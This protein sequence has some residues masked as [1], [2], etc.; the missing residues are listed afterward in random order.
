MK[1][2][3]L[4][5]IA[6]ALIIVYGLIFLIVITAMAWFSK[7]VT[8]D[9]DPTEVGAVE[10]SSLMASHA[11][12]SVS[13]YM[14]QTG[15]Y[16]DPNAQDYMF[17]SDFQ[18]ILTYSSTTEGYLT[19]LLDIIT[20]EKQIGDKWNITQLTDSQIYN[21]FTWRLYDDSY[22]DC[23]YKGTLNNTSFDCAGVGF[24]LCST[25]SPACPTCSG[26][27]KMTLS[28]GAKANCTDCEGFGSR[29]TP[30]PTCSGTG[31]VDEETCPSCAGR[32]YIRAVCRVCSGTGTVNDSPCPN[33][34]GEQYLRNLCQSCYGT[35]RNGQDD[36]SVCGGTGKCTVCSG[37][38]KY[39]CPY[40]NGTLRLRTT[41]EYANEN[42]FL[43]ETYKV[44]YKN[45]GTP[46]TRVSVDSLRK[47]SDTDVNSLP[48]RLKIFFIGEAAYS[49]IEALQ[50]LPY[51]SSDKIDSKY[52]FDFSDEDYMFSVFKITL[53]YNIGSLYSIN[54][55]MGSEG[56]RAR[57]YCASTGDNVTHY[58]T[59]GGEPVS[60]PVG[61]YMQAT[62]TRVN[63]TEFSDTEIYYTTSLSALPSNAQISDEPGLYY[64][65]DVNKN[66][67]V[68][69]EMK[70]GDFSTRP[71]HYGTFTRAYVYDSSKTYYVCDYD[72]R[73]SIE[74]GGEYMIDSYLYGWKLGGTSTIVNGTTD[75]Y[76]N[77]P[78][79]SNTMVSA[80]IR[81]KIKVDYYLNYEGASTTTPY[82]SIYVVPGKTINYAHYYER[83][84][85]ATD[86]VRA[87]YQFIG[88]SLTAEASKDLLTGN[89]SG[90]IEFNNNAVLNLTDAYNGVVTLY[91]IWAPVREYHL[92]LNDYW[93]GDSAATADYYI[94]SRYNGTYVDCSVDNE[95]D[96]TLFIPVGAQLVDYLSTRISASK[97]AMSGGVEGSVLDEIDIDSWLIKEND[98]YRFLTANT[99]V[100]FGLEPVTIYARWM[101]NFNTINVK[102][103]DMRVN[104][105]YKF[106]SSTDPETGDPVWTTRSS[107]NVKVRSSVT[108]SKVN[109]YDGYLDIPYA[110]AFLDSGY[111]YIGTC[112]SCNGSGSEE[113]TCST[114]S[115]VGT[116]KV[117]C[118]ICGGAG[119]VEVAC[120]VCQEGKVTCMDCGGSGIDDKCTKCNGT[121]KLKCETC[122]GLGV[123]GA[124][125]CPDCDGGYNTC[126]DCNGS[127]DDHYCTNCSGTGFLDCDVCGGDGLLNQLCS[128]CYQGKVTITC[129]TC[130]GA[131]KLIQVC[132]TCAGSGYDSA[133]ATYTGST[134]GTQFY[135]FTPEGF[136]IADLLDYGVFAI[137]MVSHTCSNTDY[138]SLFVNESGQF[139]YYFN[140]N[141]TLSTSGANMSG[142]ITVEGTGNEAT[143]NNELSNKIKAYAAATGM[144][145]IMG[146]EEGD[147]YYLW[148][149]LPD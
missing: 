77:N 97:V 59:T 115:G 119:S 112:S 34:D 54:F 39:F 67:A 26:T 40:C 142:T 124:A 103:N 53:N 60:L 56:K 101:R 138:Q 144:A 84:S 106:V 140:T 79:S 102:N 114:C 122:D 48:M 30:C 28:S 58:N 126:D 51:S 93:C 137:N 31:E 14:G 133:T 69:K 38:G 57:V 29:G 131:K 88:W 10:S 141:R 18:V 83:Q 99:T 13:S 74:S 86:P 96:L 134:S 4:E 73:V 1:T 16:V 148:W 19:C 136:S 81:S 24:L 139:E 21:N 68:Y 128:N 92:F 55:D 66:G 45:D 85:Y 46:I 11:D 110:V 2:L 3:K 135:I 61:D 52:T 8:V 33:C 44:L 32:K 49:Q 72:Y 43:R 9:A 15:I 23:D 100:T 91:A 109:Y 50:K 146:S 37:A 22:S 76:V 132:H 121:G 107:V 82:H 105:S 125:D 104:F 6:I 116:L 62:Y 113:V 36:C 94:K 147:T 118:P 27:G 42:G 41:S 90:G 12:L 98:E 47:T 130:D 7:T 65:L 78:I 70:V 35:G 25:C 87:G 127:G 5:K 64:F 108:V 145:T 123:L 149:A 20:I 117:N 75:N 120:S 143:D 95:Y 89:W 111:S 80:D 129:T 71:T 17:S 63:I